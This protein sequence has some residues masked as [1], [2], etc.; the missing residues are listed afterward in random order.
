[1]APA[2]F[3]LSIATASALGKFSSNIRDPIV[4]LT[5]E[6]FIKS[7]TVK[8]TPCRGDS[9]AE[10]ETSESALIA[11]SSA[12]SLHIVINAFRVS[13]VRS[14]LSRAAN[15]TSCDDISFL[16]IAFDISKAGKNARVSLF[17]FMLSRML[18][19]VPVVLL[20]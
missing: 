13:W 9:S 2:L 7:F 16:A 3:S 11:F 5:P 19:V 14:A 8:G 15:T 20:T 6:V 1:M 12:L 18:V 4:V 10:A 17:I